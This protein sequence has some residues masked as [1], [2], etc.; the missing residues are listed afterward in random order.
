MNNTVPNPATGITPTALNETGHRRATIEQ[1]KR[2]GVILGVIS[3][4]NEVDTALLKRWMGSQ[5]G[6]FIPGIGFDLP[7][8]ATTDFIRAEHKAGR[9]SVIGE[10]GAPWVGYSAGDTAYD[11]FFA[12]AEELDIPI[13]VHAGS[14]GGQA[15][16]HGSP[17][18]RMELNRPLLLEDMLA[19]P[20]CSTVLRSR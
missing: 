6:L 15:T 20:T 10:I 13:A 12:L 18:Y 3:Y 7:G 2:Y 1:M 4:E 19:R 9:L 11:K 16:Y 17:K 5:P 14:A 8:A